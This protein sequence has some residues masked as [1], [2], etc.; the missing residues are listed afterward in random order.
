MDIYIGPDIVDFDIF[1]DFDGCLTP[2]INQL[3][4]RACIEEPNQ[5]LIV[6]DGIYDAIN[7]K[8]AKENKEQMLNQ[9]R[10]NSQ[11]VIDSINDNAI[12]HLRNITFHFTL[13]LSEASYVFLNKTDTLRMIYPLIY[14][15]F[16]S[17]RRGNMHFDFD[18]DSHYLQLILRFTL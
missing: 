10:N 1:Q 11:N 13:H 8:Q 16:C 12:P 9:F 14:S 3:I 17:L 4:I 15:L 6:L 5:H 18:F 7:E 2:N